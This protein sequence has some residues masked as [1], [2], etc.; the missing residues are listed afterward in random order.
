MWLVCG[1]HVCSRRRSQIVH[2]SLYDDFIVKLKAA[3]GTVKIGDPL[4]EGTLMGPL[5]TAAAVKQYTDGIEAIKAQGGK[6][7]CGGKVVEGEGHFVEP[8][9]VEIDASAEIINT[10]LFVPILYVMKFS[11]IDEAIAMNN[12]VPQGLSSSIF[13]NNSGT[14]WK[15]LG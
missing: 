8:T 13:T 15:W 11:D 6:I 9:V 12:A 3:Y 14:M 4:E 5:H 1:T 10:E 7:L 2:E